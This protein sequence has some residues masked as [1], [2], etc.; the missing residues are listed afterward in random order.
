MKAS[1]A[2]P[3]AIQT[4]DLQAVARKARAAVELASRQFNGRL[5]WLLAGV[6]LAPSSDD[7]S[8]H[9]ESWPAQAAAFLNPT[10][11]IAAA[12][13]AM[14]VARAAAEPVVK[15]HSALPGLLAREASEWANWS[16]PTA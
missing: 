5:D 13:S 12:E 14:N 9:V 16:A 1:T 15:W 3:S 10:T 8:G 7:L 4:F 2:A 11:A 6:A